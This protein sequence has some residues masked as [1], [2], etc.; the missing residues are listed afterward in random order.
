VL[1]PLN[2]EYHGELVQVANGDYEWTT[3]QR[4]VWRFRD[5]T[6]GVLMDGRLVE[7]RDFSSNRVQ[8]VWNEGE[9]YISK[10]VDTSGGQYNFGFDSVR[11][12]YT[13]ITFQGWSVNLGYDTPNYRLISKSV[14]APPGYT[15]LNTTWQYFYGANGLLERIMD[16]RGNTN[17]LVRYDRYGR[18]TNEVDGLGRVNAYA[19]GA[20]GK[21]QITRT[22][23]E[24][25]KWTEAYDRKLRLIAETDPLGNVTRLGYDATGNIASMT[26]ALG[27][28][29]QF[30][31]DDR[32]NVVGQTNVLGEVRQWVY[33][34]FFNKAV[35]EITPQPLDVNGHTT[36]TNYY[37]IDNATGNLLSH[38]DDLGTLAAYTYTTNGLVSSR[39]DANGNVARMQYDTN[40]FL[41]LS[42]DAAGYTSTFGRN[43]WGWLMAQTNA[44]GEVTTYGYD[45]NGKVI[46]RADSLAR[47]FVRQYDEN[48]NVLADYGF[49]PEVRS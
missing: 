49:I 8:L 35:Q 30:G 31:Y 27:A 5:P 39:T 29:T 4:V 46:R 36:W 17:V 21:R 3:P 23:P 32:A 38:R 6:Q 44:L 34:P 22:D 28:K 16:P 37:A 48:G 45:L 33:H 9:G 1:K 20:T 43:E 24:G 19:Y 18:R 13:N 7:M 14:T 25:Y 2:N 10:V 47:V 11:G 26:D 42:T 41:I 12:R 15:N 40:G